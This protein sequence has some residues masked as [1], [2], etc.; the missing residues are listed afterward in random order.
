MAN[1][2]DQRLEDL[3]KV[4]APF[5]RQAY[6]PFTKEIKPKHSIFSKIGGLP[7]LRS[8]DDWPTCPNCQRH[9]QL[10]LQLNLNGLPERKAGGLIQLFYCTTDNPS[11]ET[12]LNAY[13]PFSGATVCRKIEIEGKSEI[14]QP[15]AVELFNEKQITGWKAIDDYPHFEE[16][17]DLGIDLKIDEELYDLMHKRKIGK[18]VPGDKLFGWPYWIQGKENPK[19]RNTGS[20]MEL[21]FQLD[22]EI[23]LPFMFGDSGVGHLTQS[24]ENDEE[25]AFGWACL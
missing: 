6:V 18:A 19:D 24:P 17:F 14:V 25:L 9:L 10:F 20:T 1:D 11:C 13:L 2:I 7:Y 23:N 15:T 3:L 21:L 4:L 16:Y 8:K 12:E 22:S 5:K